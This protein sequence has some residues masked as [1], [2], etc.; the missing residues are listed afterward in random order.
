MYTLGNT[1]RSVVTKEELHLVA[2]THV[3]TAEVSKGAPV[4]LNAAGTVSPIAAATDVVYGIVT[5]PGDANA[6]VTVNTQFQVIAVGVAD[7][8]ITTGNLVACS[9]Q[10]A[11]DDKLATYAAAATGNYVVGMAL[12]DATDTNEFKVGLFRTFRVLD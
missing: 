4:K 1:T 10:D 12:S 3:T 8:A 9:G 7:G 6:E 2:H 11:G 5:V